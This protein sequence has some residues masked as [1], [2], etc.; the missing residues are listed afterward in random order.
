MFHEAENYISIE[1][2]ELSVYNTI[3]AALASGNNKLNDLF[4]KTGFSRAKISVYM[5]NLMAF[6]VVEKVVSLIP[7][8]GRI[9]KR[10][11][12]ALPILM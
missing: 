3:L 1:L 10:V 6:D 12:T 7:V 11:F 5:K 9:R 2:R 8:A 4:L